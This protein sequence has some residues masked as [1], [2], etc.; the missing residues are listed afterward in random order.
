MSK[1]NI[2]ILLKS[3]VSNLG[4]SGSLIQVKPGYARNYLIPKDIAVFATPRIM[5]EAQLIFEAEEQKRIFAEQ[6]IKDTCSLLE[7]VQGIT[8]KK[9][10]G[11][12]DAIFGTVTAQEVANSL[13]KLS[14]VEI[15]KKQIEIPEIKTIGK[16]PIQI[17]FNYNL[18]SCIDLYVLPTAIL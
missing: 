2:P 18:N 7:K 17:K 6:V 16:Y 12:N 5:K 14:L 4:R 8:I 10:I 11:K 15:D 1:K 13:S 3:D 9:K